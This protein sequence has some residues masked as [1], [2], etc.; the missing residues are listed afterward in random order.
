MHVKGELE[1]I[2]GKTITDDDLRAAIKVMNKTRAAR[3]AFVK[4]ASDHWRRDLRCE[5]LR[6]APCRLVYGAR[7]VR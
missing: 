3:R 2:A 6:R 5:A 1:K 7:R 4:L